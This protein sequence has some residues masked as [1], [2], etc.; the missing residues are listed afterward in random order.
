MMVKELSRSDDK[1]GKLLPWIMPENRS[2]QEAKN[3][4]VRGSLQYLA[5]ENTRY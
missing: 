2:T 1:E 4:E 5:L 3:D